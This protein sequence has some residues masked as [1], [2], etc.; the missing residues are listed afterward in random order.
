MQEIKPCPKCG[1]T[2]SLQAGFHSR[3]GLMFHVRCSKPFCQQSS[4]TYDNS[5]D[6][7]DDWNSLVIFNSD[8]KAKII[9]TEVAE[10]IN[11]LEIKKF[12]ISDYILRAKTEAHKRFIKANAIA[13][14][15]KLL[16][17]KLFIA[18]AGTEIPMILG[19]K[20]FV[21]EDLPDDCLF[22]VF[23]MPNPP[24]TLAEQNEQLKAEN[25]ELK[26]K[27]NKIVELIEGS[28][29]DEL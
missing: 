11:A 29:E 14:S 3:K 23:Y 22:S 1:S 25:R 20:C 16:Y 5:K 17:S 13:I 15:D 28:N 21:T 10:S 6:A 27:L 8:I 12:N 9:S 7:I 26:E 19:L 4:G 24:L 2:A 18:E